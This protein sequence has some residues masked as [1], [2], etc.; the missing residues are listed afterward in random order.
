MNRKELTLRETKNGDPRIVPMTPEV[1]EA[2]RQ[3]LRERRL[4]TS[5]VF[6]YKG[7]PIQRRLT[8]ASKQHAEGRELFTAGGTAGLLLT[9]S[10]TPAQLR[11]EEQGLTQ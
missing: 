5:K 1:Y 6:L 9:I 2:F 10:G 8:T 11:C 4:D 7:R 3:C